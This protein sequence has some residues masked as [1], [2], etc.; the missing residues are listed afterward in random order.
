MLMTL[1]TALAIA[2]PSQAAPARHTIQDVAW[3]AGCWASAAGGRQVDEQWMKPAGGSMLGISRTVAKGR[4]V[5][6]EFIQMR[7][8][9]DGLF[10][11]A[12]PSGQSEARFKLVAASDG[13]VRFENP[14]HDFPQVIT[15]VRQA[16]GSLV[17]Q[18][19]GTVNGHARSIDF[20]MQRSSCGS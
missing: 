17:A 18:I 8:E 19:S 2:A 7:E 11:I 15:Y 3:I 4:T 13:S 9:A 6:T 12:L 14:G 16:D 10:Y 1:L 20:S 5:A